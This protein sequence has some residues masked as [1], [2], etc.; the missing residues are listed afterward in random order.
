M[1]SIILLIMLS[2]MAT[3]KNYRE[4]IPGEYIVK[5]NKSHMG[6]VIRKLGKDLYLIK[7]QDK[8]IELKDDVFPNYKYIGNYLEKKIPAKNKEAKK[9]IEPL[10]INQF[11][12]QQIQTLKAWE[13][14]QGSTEVIVA[15]TDNEFEIDHDA[16]KD[17]WWV[18]SREIPSNGIDDDGNGYIDDINGW[19]F[20]DKNANPDSKEEFTHG[21]HIAGIIAANTKSKTGISGIAPKVKV[22]ALR[23]YDYDAYWTTA[24]IVET[25]RYAV[26]NGARIINTSYNIDQ[27]VNDEAYLDV[28]QYIKNNGVLLVNSAGNSKTKDPARGSIKDIILVCSVTSQSIY[29]SD[30]KSAF[31]N[32]GKEIDIC[33]P[34]DPIL[35]TVQRR[36]S[37]GES[38]YGNSSGTS[39]ASPVVAATAALVWSAH[40]NYSRDEVIRTILESTDEIDSK[41]KRKFRGL[42]GSGRVNVGRSIS[43]KGI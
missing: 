17:S 7:S 26:D 9:E 13:Q 5:S 1:K 28:V 37:D 6:S 39:M 15:V 3:A 20:I 21:T 42:L 18:N 27:L 8:S 33:A 36:T 32:Y 14:T 35:S 22:M 40:P 11:H 25:Y 2:N 12:H 24:I 41:N 19:N 16:L 10:F 30:I 23:W 4:K 38:R 34:G 31:S 43:N 29:G